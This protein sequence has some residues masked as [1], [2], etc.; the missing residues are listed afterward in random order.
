M[1]NAIPVTIG[2]Q[3]DNC[4]V[5]TAEHVS[6]HHAVAFR[7]AEGWHLYDLGSTN[8]V[9]VNGK[10]ESHALVTDRDTVALGRHS[11]VGVVALGVAEERHDQLARTSSFVRI[12]KAI[13]NDMTI[14]DQHVSRY[15]AIVRRDTSGVEIF[16][17]GSSNGTTVNG[18]EKMP[19]PVTP[20]DVIGL[21]RSY[22]LEAEKVL[23][24][25]E[26]PLET[27]ASTRRSRSQTG[28]T[29]WMRKQFD[30]LSREQAD[31]LRQAESVQAEQLNQVRAEQ[32]EQLSQAKS[33][34]EQSSLRLKRGIMVAAAV[35][36]VVIGGGSWFL[37]GR[38]PQRALVEG[39]EAAR[40]SVVMV[41]HEPAEAVAMDTTDMVLFSNDSDD[42]IVATG[43]IYR[44]GSQS[45]VVTNKHVV[46]QWSAAERANLNPGRL[47]VRTQGQTRSYEVEVVASHPEE[48]VAVLRFTGAAPNCPG[49]QM[50]PSIEGIGPGD[51][52]ACLSF[53]LGLQDQRSDR[54]QAD[55]VIGTI[56]NIL[57]GQLKYNLESA[58][59]A[60]GGPVF[61]ADG[62]V[63]A[64][65]Q[66]GSAHRGVVVQGLNF[67]VQIQ[68]ALE[69]IGR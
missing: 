67:G 34:Q 24:V 39:A 23:R 37:F 64:V 30:R 59:G 16:D 32:A 18:S 7:V 66:R 69:V 55:L 51:P 10:R 4:L 56:T 21:G 31:Q 63:I 9:Y 42:Q 47:E 19:A 15:H 29:T 20:G 53:P 1:A 45:L 49:V 13:D 54:L 48:D 60:S 38:S 25:L 14:E 8:G 61:G 27:P 33:E 3:E 5:V 62:R 58:P 40:Q 43:F 65:N 57:D 6:R 22:R 46:S 44:K 26:E 68:Y 11:D 12:G 35:A 50:N 36:L 17:A 28:K 52:V 2:S 41:V